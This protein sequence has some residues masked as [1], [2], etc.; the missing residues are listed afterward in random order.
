MVS[1]INSFFSIFNFLG[2]LTFVDTG[3]GKA[4]Q[5]RRFNPSSAIALAKTK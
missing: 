2:F 1:Y 3:R 4:S 5:I